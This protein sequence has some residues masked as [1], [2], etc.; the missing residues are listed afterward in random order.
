MKINNKQSGFTILELMIATSV[1][2]V[3]LLVGSMMLLQIG[4]MYYRGVNS[5]RAQEVSR[6]VVEDISRKIQFT[7]A[8]IS[9]DTAN[10]GGVDVT[11]Y[12]VG[13][14]RYSFVTN[15][16]VVAEGANPADGTV[17]HGLWKD[18]NPDSSNN[19]CTALDIVTTQP[20]SGE[21]LL[22]ENMRI[23]EF[24]VGNKEIIAPAVKNPSSMCEV[25]AGQGDQFG[26]VS[27][28]I[29]V[30]FGESDLIRYADGIAVG[31][32][33]QTGSQWCASSQLK[34]QVFRRL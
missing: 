23:G 30:L 21:E 8:T 20:A 27:I 26:G 7:P 10:F 22:S 19:S 31:C 6:N 11:S 16:M 18:V 28:N 33:T 34:T 25:S 1:F 4:K 29:R 9:S 5:A 2:S 3:I 32:G 15:L 24:C 17:A 12:C 14:T 13:T